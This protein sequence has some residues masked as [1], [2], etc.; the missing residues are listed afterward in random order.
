MLIKKPSDVAI[1]P[2]EMEDAEGVGNGTSASGAK[3]RCSYVCNA[4]V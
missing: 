3:R 4:N 1:E 2:V